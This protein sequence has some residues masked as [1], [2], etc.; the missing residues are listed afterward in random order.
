[1]ALPFSLTYSGNHQPK[2]NDRLSIHMIK[3]Q[4]FPETHLTIYE[5]N[6]DF[7]EFRLILFRI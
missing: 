7:G 4:F 2:P 6:L 3:V 1:M 5:T